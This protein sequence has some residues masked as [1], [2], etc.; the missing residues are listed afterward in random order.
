VNDN[1]HFPVLNDLLGVPLGL[2]KKMDFYHPPIIQEGM[3]IFMEV[4]AAEN[5]AV[6]NTVPPVIEVEGPSGLY[7]EGTPEKVSESSGITMKLRYWWQNRVFRCG[8]TA[9]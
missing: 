7:T 8:L 4:L 9:R 1:G 6:S 3:E 2:T 5:I